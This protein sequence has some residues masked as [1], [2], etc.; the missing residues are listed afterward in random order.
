MRLS[1]RALKPMQPYHTLAMRCKCYERTL[2][3]WLE[4]YELVAHLA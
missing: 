4:V 2:E 3:A 1:D